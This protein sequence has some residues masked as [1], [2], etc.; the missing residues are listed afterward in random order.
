MS[1]QSSTD[2]TIEAEF[3][4]DVYKK[5]DSICV[6]IEWVDVRSPDRIVLKLT[7]D[8]VRQLINNLAE[9]LPAESNE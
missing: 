5:E 8:E 2:P 7:N 3:A 6:D 4:I 9:Q 1:D